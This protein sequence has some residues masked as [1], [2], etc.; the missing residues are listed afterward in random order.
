MTKLKTK[1][2][3]F[4]DKNSFEYVFKL[5][6]KYIKQTLDSD[7]QI[8]QYVPNSHI[9]QSFRDVLIACEMEDMYKDV[10]HNLPHDD[11]PTISFLNVIDQYFNE[12]LLKQNGNDEI[13]RVYQKLREKY[14]YIRNNLKLIDTRIPFEYNMQHKIKKDLKSHKIKIK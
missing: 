2:N 8:N 10:Y 1:F 11:V 9:A 7:I 4:L 12:E 5:I 3:D 14:D 6:S 13:H